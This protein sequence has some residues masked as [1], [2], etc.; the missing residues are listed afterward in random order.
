MLRSVF[1]LWFTV[2][3][4]FRVVGF[5][6]F[7]LRLGCRSFKTECVAEYVL[8]TSSFPCAHI[9][10]FWWMYIGLQVLAC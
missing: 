10:V 9:L 1:G 5:S 4:V 6:V 8:H 3:E 7:V 2:F